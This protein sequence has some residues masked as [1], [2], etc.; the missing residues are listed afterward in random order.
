MNF[1][2]GYFDKDSKSFKKIHSLQDL[3]GWI[4][5]EENLNR[6]KKK[7]KNKKLKLL[8]FENNFDKE[9]TNRELFTIFNKLYSLNS[10]NYQK[11]KFSV[12]ILNFYNERLTKE[13]ILLFLT[14]FWHI[15]GSNW[16]DFNFLFKVWL[17]FLQT[18]VLDI[19]EKSIELIWFQDALLNITT[20]D[21]F[22]KFLLELPSFIELISIQYYLLV[23][24]FS[25]LNKKPDHFIEE[26]H[27]STDKILSLLLDQFCRYE[28]QL[29]EKIFIDLLSL[30]I[31][32]LDISNLER[33]SNFLRSTLQ[34]RL[35]KRIQSL[36]KL[37]L[38]IQQCWQKRLLSYSHFLEFILLTGKSVSKRK[39]NEYVSK[40]LGLYNSSFLQLN[41]ITSLLDDKKITSFL[42]HRT[43]QKIFN[44]F[45]SNPE[46][47][48]NMQSLEFYLSLKKGILSR[49]NNLQN[50]F[51]II[52][53]NQVP[54][55]SFI[56]FFLLQNSKS[57]RRYFKRLLI[58]INS[59]N[60]N[61]QFNTISEKFFTL[62]EKITNILTYMNDENLKKYIF[63][64]TYEMIVKD[65]RYSSLIPTLISSFLDLLEEE[66]GK[67]VAVK[68]FLKFLDNQNPLALNANHYR[69]FL[70][71]AYKIATREDY[72]LKL[73]EDLNGKLN[74]FLESYIQYSNYLIPDNEKLEFLE[75]LLTI[76][77]VEET[78]NFILLWVKNQPNLNVRIIAR[79]NKAVKKYS[80][81]KE[82]DTKQTKEFLIKDIKCGSCL[83]E[84]TESNDK[85]SCE[86]CDITL[87][88]TC[89]IEFEFSGENCPGAIF[90]T[91]IHKF[92]IRNN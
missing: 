84:I 49:S 47:F 90:G 70:R 6:R 2:K 23:E 78:T 43:K 9:D 74:T 27:I 72:S 20:P 35:Q 50:F 25:Y 48:I 46:I 83:R 54:W 24:S 33:F 76:N 79:G 11:E 21:T 62:L 65:E 68:D 57:K 8:N 12:R 60:F 28:N 30:I 38:F 36:R 45:E 26:E 19:S 66:T 89:F 73:K 64:T 52:F 85:K 7:T 37:L 31:T 39:N 77:L 75:Y 86:L 63:S 59:N 87:C 22:E 88:I 13:E 1:L 56:T 55:Q 17:K 82:E 4:S 92:K 53:Q 16:S 14:S 58:Y 34:K 67:N 69:L 91:K 44:I 15:N 41:H 42:T 5:Q 71:D 32:S 51:Q 3:K 40:V 10:S 29:L 18:D 80:I 61:M 81:L